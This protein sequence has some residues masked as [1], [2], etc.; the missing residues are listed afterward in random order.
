MIWITGE[1]HKH[2]PLLGAELIPESSVL[3]P[4]WKNEQKTFTL[5]IPG[6]CSFQPCGTRLNYFYISETLAMF[7]DPT[8]RIWLAV[9]SKSRD[10]WTGDLS[11]ASRLRF[12]AMDAFHNVVAFRLV[13]RCLII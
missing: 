3:K 6:K 5:T 12:V 1:I 13:F 4:T 2:T 11:S 7:I 9:E 8:I 10:N